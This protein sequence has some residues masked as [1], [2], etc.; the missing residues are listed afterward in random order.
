MTFR[1]DLAEEYAYVVTTDYVPTHPDLNKGLDPA[2][3]RLVNIALQGVSDPKL[4]SSAQGRAVVVKTVIHEL[5][6]T[7][8]E[9]RDMAN[10]DSQV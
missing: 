1:R 5:D 8:V 4:P 7:D 2:Q 6:A 10:G 9:L 3:A